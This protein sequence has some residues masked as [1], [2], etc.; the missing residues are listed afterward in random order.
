MSFP[1]RE[2]L[3]VYLRAAFGAAW[4]TYRSPAAKRFAA[5]LTVCSSATLPCAE[6]LR[7]VYAGQGRTEE[8]RQALE[9]TTPTCGS[10]GNQR[11]MY[12]SK[13]F[14]NRSECPQRLRIGP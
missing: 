3:S 8:E 13:A 6:Q 1:D 7:A 5:S 2:R 9:L 4:R 14:P 12:A 11:L 10:L